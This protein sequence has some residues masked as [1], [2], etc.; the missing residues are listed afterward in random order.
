MWRAW[1]SQ[2]GRRSLV[3]PRHAAS[4]DVTPKAKATYSSV[5]ADDEPGVG[6]GGVG[7]Q[8]EFVIQVSVMGAELQTDA[9]HVGP[10]VT[11]SLTDLLRRQQDAPRAAAPGALST[12]LLLSGAHTTDLQP[13]AGRSVS[14]N[15]PVSSP[16][17]GRPGELKDTFEV[18]GVHL[19]PVDGPGVAQAEHGPLLAAHLQDSLLV[20]LEEQEEASVTCPTCGLDASVPSAPRAGPVDELFPIRP[21]CWR[22]DRHLE[23][24]N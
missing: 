12:A 21:P 5:G 13:A 15:T 14:W 16:V 8:L 23:G 1:R 3:P 10:G 6:G 20:H 18:A 2:L 19:H 24:S 7:R 9:G 11:A 17:W 4:G 22:L